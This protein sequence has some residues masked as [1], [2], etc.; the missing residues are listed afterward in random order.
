MER[1]NERLR[2]E[3]RLRRERIGLLGDRTEAKAFKDAQDEM[4]KDAEK[5]RKNIEGTLGD[6]LRA[7]LKGD[8]DSIGKMWGNLLLDMAAKALAA[9]IMDAVFGNAK[10]QQGGGGGGSALAG[11]ASFFASLFGGGRAH[12]GPVSAGKMYEVNELGEPE[13]LTAGGRDYLMMGSK[14]GSVSADGGGMSVVIDQRGMSF[15]AG[16]NRN[17]LMAG[18]AV[19]RDQAIS[20]IIEAQTRGPRF[21]Q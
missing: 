21:R 19:A 18:M 1:E 17:E 14:P 3:I 16:V 10:G 11:F 7:G 2:E 5:T 15:G 13:V 12:G 8:F 9:N 6:S 20:A 4:A